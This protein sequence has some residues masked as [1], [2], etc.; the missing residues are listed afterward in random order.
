MKGWLEERGVRECC[1]LARPL[2]GQRGGR[3]TRRDLLARASMLP[4]GRALGVRP[5]DPLVVVARGARAP[6]LAAAT[7]AA[8]ALCREGRAQPAE[9][10]ANPQRR[11]VVQLLDLEESSSGPA[12][13]WG[14]PAL[15]RAV[16]GPSATGWELAPGV[17]PG[18]WVLPTG[19]RRLALGVPASGASRPR[20]VARF[21]GL[22]GGA[23]EVQQ[24]A[25]GAHA[26]GCV[27]L[28]DTAGCGDAAVR[29]VRTALQLGPPSA[30]PSLAHVDE[31]DLRA[32]SLDALAGLVVPGGHAGA[33]ARAL[34]P[35][36][37]ARLV[38]WVRGGGAYLGICAGAYLGTATPPWGLGLLPVEVHDL[39]HWRRGTGTVT[40]VPTPDARRELGLPEAGFAVR[41]A[42]G[43]LLGSAPGVE[44]LLRFA[45]SLRGRAPEAAPLAGQGAWIQGRSGAGRV[46]L[47]SPHLEATPGREPLLGLAARRLMGW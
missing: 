23:A 6:G 46:A 34:G 41:Y 21:L 14:A 22:M 38:R 16:L 47:L 24:R 37:R 4:L 2:T 33:Q 29:A 44:V 35:E 45:G 5:V 31:Q 17:P 3:S 30:R 15:A 13:V 42:N 28:L 1:G 36:G 40:V 32:G 19:D 10:V 9:S 8:E 43:P 11:L 18:G 20:R 26:P 12:R 7:L 25:L 39:E 27:G